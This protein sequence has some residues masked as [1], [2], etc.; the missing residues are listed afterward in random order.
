M[1]CCCRVLH[2]V[3][4]EILGSMFG[5]MLRDNALLPHLGTMLQRILFDLLKALEQADEGQGQGAAG[6]MLLRHDTHWAVGGQQRHADLAQVS[7]VL[8]LGTAIG[9]LAMDPA[10]HRDPVV[11][12]QG[13]AARFHDF[14]HCTMPA[15]PNSASPHLGCAGTTTHAS[16]C[17]LYMQ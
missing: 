14:M 3:C 1:N 7:P 12:S 15:K 9:C 10:V 11:L 2:A 16:S 5:S 17:G 6:G 4:A 13:S 8:Y